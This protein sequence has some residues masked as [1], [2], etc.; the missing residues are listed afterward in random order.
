MSL[1][2]FPE[3]LAQLALENLAGSRQWQRVLADLDAA[4]ALVARD[5]RLAEFDQFVRRDLGAALGDDQPARR[6]R[7][8]SE[9]A[10]PVE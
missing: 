3:R 4:R 10:T 2:V 8:H 7:I 1:P 9:E 6:S 5:Q